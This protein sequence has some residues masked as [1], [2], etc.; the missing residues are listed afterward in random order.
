MAT[1]NPWP[2]IV[3]C[4]AFH[5]FMGIFSGGTILEPFGN[6]GAVNGIGD[7]F[8]N[9]GTI[10]LGVVNF[11]WTLL[12]FDYGFPVIIRLLAT[13]VCN[14]PILWSMLEII[15]PRGIAALVAVAAGIGLVDFLAG[16]FS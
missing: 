9:L 13:V 10:F 3:V 4:T 8:A 6:V 16:L 11:I 2:F 1:L 7:I 12:S 15:G 14:G 5:V